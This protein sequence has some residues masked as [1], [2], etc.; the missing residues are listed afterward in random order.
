MWGLEASIT[1]LWLKRLALCALCFYL[2]QLIYWLSRWGYSRISWQ[3]R[4]NHWRDM[5]QQFGQSKSLSQQVT[6]V[7]MRS[8]PTREHFPVISANFKHR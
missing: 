2:C 6:V 3:L 8:T 1:L 5:R 4:M 7:S